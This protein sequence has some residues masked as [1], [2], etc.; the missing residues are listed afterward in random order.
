VLPTLKTLLPFTDEIS[1]DVYQPYKAT[2]IPRTPFKIK[3]YH[4]S[5]SNVPIFGLKLC[6]QKVTKLELCR[7]I[8]YV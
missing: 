1:S 2:H 3:T 5:C 8:Y 7:R 6:G 4:L